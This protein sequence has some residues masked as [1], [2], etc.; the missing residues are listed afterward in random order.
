MVYLYCQQGERQKTGK[1]RGEH[2]NRKQKKKRAN[3]ATC[4]IYDQ[5]KNYN[6][7]IF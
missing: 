5:G 7:A 4:K 6:G 2:E 1:E 3:D